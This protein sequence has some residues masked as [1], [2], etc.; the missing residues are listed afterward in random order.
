MQ[1]I[2]RSG[3]HWIVVSNFNGCIQ[4]FDTLYERLKKATE[5]I[6]I[7]LFYSANDNSKIQMVNSCRQV[8]STDCG[9]F[10]VAIYTAL[11]FGTTLKFNQ[12]IMRTHAAKCFE[13]GKMTPFP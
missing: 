9:L 7:E 6:I 1:I 4:V 13:L 3:N 10:A 2:H 11:C 5:D 12:M 8:G